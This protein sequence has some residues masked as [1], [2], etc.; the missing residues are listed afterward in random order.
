MSALIAIRE[1]RAR[2]VERAAAEREELGRQFAEWER[3]LVAVDRGVAVVRALKRTPLLRLGA[4]VGMAALAFVRPRSI[5]GWVVG[6][7][8]AY[9][10]LTRVH[11]MVKRTDSGE[12]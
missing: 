11:G 2:L 6:G 4:A 7:Q 12:R 1:H 10:L 9:R 3:P 5:M 8:A